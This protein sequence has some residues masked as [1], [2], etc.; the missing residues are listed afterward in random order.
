MPAPQGVSAVEIDIVP[1]AGAGKT[2]FR[3]GAI[4]FDRRIEGVATFAADLIQRVLD[5]AHAEFTDQIRKDVAVNVSRAAAAGKCE[6]ENADEPSHQ[7][8]L[9]D[10]RV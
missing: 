1:D 3:L 2:Y 10:L 6:T 8:Q 4:G 7:L 5:T 9:P